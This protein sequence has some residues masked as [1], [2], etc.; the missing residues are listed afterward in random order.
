[1]LN[2][3]SN[4]CAVLWSLPRCKELRTN[5]GW[6]CVNCEL[7]TEYFR[8]KFIMKFGLEVI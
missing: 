7:I 8:I 2:V 5:K 4:S 1:M 6:K 3:E